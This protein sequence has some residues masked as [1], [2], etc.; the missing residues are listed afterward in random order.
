MW[1]LLS[2]L[3]YVILKLIYLTQYMRVKFI[4]IY[5]YIYTNSYI[6]VARCAYN[7]IYIYIY[8]IKYIWYGGMNMLNLYLYVYALCY[9]IYRYDNQIMKVYVFQL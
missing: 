8:H 3:S 5:I 6:T 2:D 1:T 9:T 7:R 4:K